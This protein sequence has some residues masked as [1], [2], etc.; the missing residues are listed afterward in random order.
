MLFF[1]L[2]TSCRRTATE[3][4]VRPDPGPETKPMA[5]SAA[6]ENEID[7][8]PIADPAPFV[9]SPR[10]VMGSTHGC[11]LDTDGHASCWGDNSRGALGD[12]TTTSHH[13]DLVRVALADIVSIGAGDDFTCAL[14]RDRAVWCWGTGFHAIFPGQDPQ[15][16][17]V[18]IAGL[19][20]VRVLQVNPAS[21]CVASDDDVLCWGTSKFGAA[22]H[23]AVDLTSTPQA[24]KLGKAVAIGWQ[25][26]GTCA[27]LRGDGTYE[28]HQPKQPPTVLSSPATRASSDAVLAIRGGVSS[29]GWT[30]LADGAVHLD[31]DTNGG[32]TH[33]VLKLPPARSL[34]NGVEP[35]CAVVHDGRVFCWGHNFSGELGDGTVGVERDAPGPVAVLTDAISV[36]GRLGHVCALTRDR[37]IWCWGRGYDGTTGA[38]ARA[39]KKPELFAKF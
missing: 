7:R 1:V 19:P 24:M 2:G 9:A 28:V 31:A 39:S 34:A 18:Q 29:R 27:I 22:D 35:T 14:T 21:V 36:S 37:K 32:V 33:A 17:P 12:G 26:I 13:T 38:A 16:K 5:M 3:T 11:V 25:N 4:A 8:T 20:K 30:V 15:P 6:A 10:V 23:P